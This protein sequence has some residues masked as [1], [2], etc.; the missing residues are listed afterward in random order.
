MPP[1]SAGTRAFSTSSTPA[2]AAAGISSSPPRNPAGPWSGP[3]VAPRRSTG[4]T[5][6]FLRCRRN[7]MDRPQWSAAR[8]APL[9]GPHGHLARTL[10]PEDIGDV[11]SAPGAG[12]CGPA[13]GAGIRCGSRG[14]TSSGRTAS[15]TSSPPRAG[16][17]RAIPKWSSEATRSRAP[18]RRSRAI[19]SSLSAISPPDRES[20]ITSTGHASFVKTQRGD[21]WAMFL[22]VRPYDRANNFN[23]GRETFLMPVQWKDGWPRVTQPGERVPWTARRPDRPIRSR[24]RRAAASPCGTSSMAPPTI[25]LDDAAQPAAAMVAIVGG[26]ASARSTAD[27]PG[28]PRQSVVSCP[29]PAAPQ[30]RGDHQARE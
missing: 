5:P 12:R 23:T 11:R 30:C 18:T 26:S 14:R 28:R 27:R 3:G 15:I 1:T 13:S 16:P 29:A 20:P 2:S 21:W 8:Q 25:L 9:R 22:G 7:G 17:R 19:R 10:R 4:S 24:S 6:R